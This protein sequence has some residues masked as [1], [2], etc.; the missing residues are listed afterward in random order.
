M[1]VNGNTITSNCA[2]I[3]A[4]GGQ[5]AGVTYTP[6]TN[7]HITHNSLTLHTASQR[8]TQ[9]HGG[10]N[11]SPGVLY[12]STSNNLYDYNVYHFPDDNGAGLSLK[13]FQ[14]CGVT[15]CTNGTTT[16]G[17]YTFSDWKNL[18]HQDVHGCADNGSG[19]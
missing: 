14:W 10:S 4:S 5:R 16:N 9:V 1:E 7:I 2:G 12:D 8:L 3:L 13:H 18:Q 19:C 15:P 11:V 17:Q 6:N